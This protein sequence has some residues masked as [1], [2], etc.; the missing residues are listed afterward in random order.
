MV[1][2][3]KQIREKTFSKGIPDFVVKKALPIIEKTFEREV[4]SLIN[5]KIFNS[6]SNNI[7]SCKFLK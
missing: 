1:V 6:S 7:N 3:T 2:N 5:L 4:I